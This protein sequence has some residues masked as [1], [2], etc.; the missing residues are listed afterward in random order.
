MG[1]DAS[2]REKEK[3]HPRNRVLLRTKF[4]GKIEDLAELWEQG[5]YR[6]RDLVILDSF[7]CKGG[8]VA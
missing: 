7:T 2:R 8:A 1:S 6:E 4:A 5:V 3:E